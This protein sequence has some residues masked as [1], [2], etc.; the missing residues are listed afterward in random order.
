M[1]AATT[2]MITMAITISVMLMA[3]LWHMS[4]GSVQLDQARAHSIGTPHVFVIGPL[5]DNA[6]VEAG[7]TVPLRCP[8][9]ARNSPGWR[10]MYSRTVAMNRLVS[11]ASVAVPEPSS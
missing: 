2:P 1:T 3:R 11:S 5:A 10:A 7:A 6:A 8:N 9:R 4:S